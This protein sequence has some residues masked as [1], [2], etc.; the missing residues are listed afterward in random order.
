MS[1]PVR[2][3]VF[4]GAL[5]KLGR[6]KLYI[7]HLPGLVYCDMFI[8][9]ILMKHPW[10]A[11]YLPAFYNLRSIISF[12]TRP[13]VLTLPGRQQEVLHPPLLAPDVIPQQLPSV[14]F[15]SRRI[16]ELGIGTGECR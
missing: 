2:L 13:E 9:D 1:H 10:R 4:F 7:G 16:L 3:S 12:A 11:F 8:V 14:H 6:D 5:F 15:V